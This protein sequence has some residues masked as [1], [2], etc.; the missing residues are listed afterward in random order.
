MLKQSADET[1]FGDALAD[2]GQLRE[3][4]LRLSLRDRDEFR[5]SDGDKSMRCSTVYAGR[6]LLY[7]LKLRRIID[8]P[9]LRRRVERLRQHRGRMGCYESLPCGASQISDE[10]TLSVRLKARL[11][12]VN[13][14]NRVGAHA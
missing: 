10:D 2:D 9:R 4:C 12:F 8:A 11:W 3:Q 6:G 1:N 13:Y 7:F 5:A 14:G